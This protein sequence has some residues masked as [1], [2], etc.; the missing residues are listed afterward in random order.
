M[1]GIKVLLCAGACRPREKFTRSIT[2]PPNLDL[3]HALLHAHSLFLDRLQSTKN[4]RKIQV[5]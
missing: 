3:D 5:D 4:Y 1:L 2:S